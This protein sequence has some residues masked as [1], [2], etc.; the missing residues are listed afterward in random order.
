ME[1][2]GWIIWNQWSGTFRVVRVPAGTRDSLPGITGTRPWE[3]GGDTLI[4]WFHT[5]PNTADEGYSPDPSPGD[6]AFTNGYAKV[7]GV[8]ETHDGRRII[9]YPP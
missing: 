6:V 9:P 8:I 7:P 2:G 5:H 4:A 3:W 1:Q